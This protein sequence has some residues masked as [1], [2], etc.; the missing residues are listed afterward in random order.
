MMWSLIYP[1]LEISAPA[2]R[3]ICLL[4]YEKK[5][6]TLQH[7]MCIFLFSLANHDYF[8]G[9]LPNFQ[10]TLLSVDPAKL[11]MAKCT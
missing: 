8:P 3:R 11:T 1:H 2:F 10:L 4:Q 5:T 9:Y 6:H 7:F